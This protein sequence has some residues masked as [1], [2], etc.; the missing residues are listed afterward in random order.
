VIK[1]QPGFLSE[2]T[3]IILVKRTDGALEPYMNADAVLEWLNNCNITG[4]AFALHK[5]ILLTYADY[6][7]S[8]KGST[9]EETE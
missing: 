4:Q 5:Q 2:H 8:E 3:G 7:Q 9:D 1:T 6:A